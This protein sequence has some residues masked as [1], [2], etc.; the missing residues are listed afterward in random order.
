M[1][2]ADAISLN[3]SGKRR[4]CGVDAAIAELAGRQHGVVA[5]RQLARL[6]LGANVIEHRVVSHRLHP[7]HRGVYAVGHRVLT[8]NGTWMAAVLAV[9]GSVLSHRSAAALWD[10]R[11]TDR[12]GVEITVPRQLRRRPRLELHEARLPDDEVT[13]RHGIPITTVA[14][15]I[16]DLAAVLSKQDFERTATEAEIQ[17]LGSPT[18]LADLVARHPR[19]KGNTAVRELLAAQSI[20]RNVTRK[21]LELR[22]LTFL[23]T[24]GLPRPR[25]NA[26][27]DLEPKDAEVDCLWEDARL[28]AELDGFAVHGTRVRFE[29]DRARDRALQVAGYRVVRVTWRQLGD[30]TS[31]LAC[32]L[33][34]LIAR[35][36]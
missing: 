15:T 20:G 4:L 33:R 13:T 7:V 19:R 24:H 16:F 18:S 1:R 29:S 5:R 25:V 26:T 11:Q 28:V 30:D 9:D 34:A 2:A 22:F 10:I 17:R 31:L 14:R 35:D 23:D 3:I 21:D 12:P 27:V 36:P 8:R 32:Q 6:G